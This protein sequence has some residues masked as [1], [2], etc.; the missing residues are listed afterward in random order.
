MTKRRNVAAT[1]VSA[2]SHSQIA[3][4]HAPVGDKPY[5]ILVV[6]D[7]IV[8]RN[9][10]KMALAGHPGLEVCYEASDGP[11]AIE[12]VK[13]NKPDLV[14]LDLTMPKMDG[15]E[16]TQAIREI[17]PDTNVLILTMHFSKEIARD[18]LRSGARGYVLKSDSETDLV[19]AIQQVR[20]GEP[21][22][23]GQMVTSVFQD[24]VAGVDLTAPDGPIP[25]TSLTTREVEIITLLAEGKS[26]KE[27]AKSLGVSTR[28]IECHR[29]H[30]MRKMKFQSFSDVVRFAIRSKLVTA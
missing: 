19:N 25:G 1:S 6:D 28:T 3:T 21:V 8:V 13:Q 5:R 7:H 24:F 2:P 23:V 10:V 4:S 18:V 27:V 15:L 26:N 20:R 29:N 14:L 22:I 11:E 9:G 16:V 17:S 30:I 12:I